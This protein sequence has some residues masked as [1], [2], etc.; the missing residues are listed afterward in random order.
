MKPAR[1]LIFVSIAWLTSCTQE[2]EL[3]KREEILAFLKE[4]LPDFHQ[5]YLEDSDEELLYEAEEVREEWLEMK[6]V[7]PKAADAFLKM[8]TLEA[9]ATQLADEM[10]LSKDES[11]IDELKKLLSDQFDARRN[12]QGRP[13]LHERGGGS[14]ARYRG[15]RPQARRPDQQCWGFYHYRSNHRRW[16]GHPVCC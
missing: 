15:S 8:L 16:F 3:E 1:L 4:R 5:E 7:E 13:L 2:P 9:Q 6:A 10:V 11:R 14:R 12:L